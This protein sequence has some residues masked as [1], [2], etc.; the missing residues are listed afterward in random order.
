M[1]KQQTAARKKLLN[2]LIRAVQTERKRYAKL[3]TKT[4]EA[5]HKL[6]KEREKL[7]ARSEAIFKQVSDNQ[8]NED[9]GYTK[10]QAALSKL[11]STLTPAEFNDY[12][13]KLDKVKQ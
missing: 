1:N 12:M 4:R 5:N 2:K 10:V 7:Q 8:Q 6:F 13:D 3:Q 11:T 9:E